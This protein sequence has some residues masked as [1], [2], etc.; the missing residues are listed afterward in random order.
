MAHR[1]RKAWAA[2]SAE[3]EAMVTKDALVYS[4]RNLRYGLFIAQLSVKHAVRIEARNGYDLPSPA[5]A[6]PSAH[7]VTVMGVPYPP[8]T[9]PPTDDQIFKLVCLP[10]TFHMESMEH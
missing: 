2:L 4:S 6:T 5:A 3:V 9:L 1:G 10:G 7:Y 8:K